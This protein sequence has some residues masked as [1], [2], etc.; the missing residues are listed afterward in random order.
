[1]SAGQEGIKISSHFQ[2]AF[3][4][5]DIETSQPFPFLEQLKMPAEDGKVC[6]TDYTN[7]FPNQSEITSTGL[8][9]RGGTNCTSPL[10][11]K[12]LIAGAL[13]NDLSAN[14]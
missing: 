10:T 12:L 7:T 5:N 13:N 6:E 3:E 1:M 11:Q 9:S 4:K 8:G 2:I 14:M